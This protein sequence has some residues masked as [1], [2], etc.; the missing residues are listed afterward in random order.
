M[1]VV[2]GIGKPSTR[3]WRL[4]QRSSSGGAAVNRAV[5][6]GVSA[7]VASTGVPVAPLAQNMALYIKRYSVSIQENTSAEAVFL[8]QPPIIQLELGPGFALGT[9][10]LS[11]S[12]DL[13]GYSGSGASANF[14]GN[15]GGLGTIFSVVD[16]WL[17]FDDYLAGLPIFSTI[18]PLQN[19]PL[20]MATNARAH[21]ASAGALNVTF[22]ESLSYELWQRNFQLVQP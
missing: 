21:N 2:R 7:Q 5:G 20:Q 15:L 18:S 19:A 10:V 3:G 14:F 1:P 6:A 16:D 22:T 12:S 8:T 13:I 4:L 17:E 9:A 11:W